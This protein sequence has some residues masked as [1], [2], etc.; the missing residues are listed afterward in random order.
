MVY[1]KYI[2]RGGKLHGPYYY[3]SVRDSKGKIQHVYLG[4]KKPTASSK[5]QTLINSYKPAPLKS[6][7]F[8]PPTKQP[9][10][11]QPTRYNLSKNIFTPKSI[12]FTFIVLLLAI[13]FFFL[14]NYGE[15]TGRVV[16]DI[17]KNVSTESYL[18]IDGISRSIPLT[19]SRNDEGDYYFSISQLDLDL[20][21]GNHTIQLSENQ[22]IVYETTVIVPEQLEPAEELNITLPESTPSLT[23]PELSP[24]IE[25]SPQELNVSLPE[26]AEP[27]PLLSE[28]NR[29][30]ETVIEENTGFIESLAVP[31][32]G[33]P[34]LN[35]T[36]GFNRTSENITLYNISTADTDGDVVKN[37]IT[38]YKNGRSDSVGYY[39]FENG[40]SN[41]TFTKN[42]A[43]VGANGT[44]NATTF[45]RT[46]G[47]DGRGA[48]SFTPTQD[49][50]ILVGNNL[51]NANGNFSVTAW[52]NIS[53]L[54]HNTHSIFGLSRPTDPTNNGYLIFIHRIANSG[55]TLQYDLGV[56]DASFTNAPSADLVPNRWAFVAFTRDSAN[57]RIRIYINDTEVSSTNANPI[58]DNPS[59]MDIV[60]GKWSATQAANVFN[61]TIDEVRIYNYSLSAEQIKAIYAN[62][63]NIIVAQQL[64]ATDVWQGC[65]TPHDGNSDGQIACSNN[66]TIRAN[67]APTHTAPILNATSLT[68]TTLT[69]LTVYNQTT[70]D[71]EGDVVKN[72]ITWNTNVTLVSSRVAPFA[73][74]YYPFEGRDNNASAKDYGRGVLN[75]T[76]NGSFF[77]PTGGFDGRGA[78]EFDAS[79]DQ[80]VTPIDTI[81]QNFTV[82]AWIK[83]RAI[84]PDAGTFGVIVSKLTYFAIGTDSFPFFFIVNHRAANV[85]CAIDAGGDFSQDLELRS[86]GDFGANQWH[87]VAC[88]YNSTH[89]SVYV[90]GKLNATSAST[91]T[92][93][94]GPGLNYTIGRASLHN[95]GGN[96]LTYFNGTIDEVMIFNRSL[97]PRQIEAIYNNRTDL[98]ISSELQAGQLWNSCITPND[99]IDDGV[100][101]CS[102]NV[103]IIAAGTNNLP[104][105]ATPI[106]N[107]TLGTNLTTE[108]L[109]VY[110]RSTNDID[111]D[112]VKNIINWYSNH[113][114][115]HP[116]LTS[117]AALNL[118]FEGG[119]NATFTKDY[120]GFALPINVTN[121]NWNATGGIDAKG[122]Y[123]FNGSS[124]INITAREINFTD[125]ITISVWIKPKSI[126]LGGIIGKWRNTNFA[127]LIWMNANGNISWVINNSN[128]LYTPINLSVNNWN[129]IAV[130][131]NGTAV[132]LYQNGTLVAA[133]AQT[134]KIAVENTYETLIGTYTNVDGGPYNYFNGTID[135]ILIFNRSLS[136]EQIRAIYDNRTDL[137]VSQELEKSQVWYSCITPNDGT[138]D[139]TEICSNNVTIIKANSAPTHSNP[140]LNSTFK[141]NLSSENFTIYFQ[142][143]ADAD[144]DSVQNITDWRRNGTSIAI[145]NM[146]FETNI[147]VNTT[148]ITDY[149]T[150]GIHGVLGNGSPLSLP[151][152]NN[153]GKIGGAYLFNGSNVINLGTSTSA[154][155]STFTIT[156]WIK[157]NYSNSQVLL[158][159]ASGGVSTESNYQLSVA[160]TFAFTIGNGSGTNFVV[161]TT[162]VAT[163]K[164]YF[165]AATYNNA[166]QQL[167][168]YV[169]G[170]FEGNA[171]LRGS[172]FTT[173]TQILKIGAADGTGNDN[174]QVTTGFNGTIDEVMIYNRS[175]SAQQLYQL[176]LDGN[177]SKH[178]ERLV[179]NETRKG[180]NW[181]VAVTPNDNSTDGTILISNGLLILN[182][183]PQHTTPLLNS[184]LGTNRSNE[185]LTVYNQSTFDL[186]GDSVKNIINWK[187]DNY[188]ITLAN[189]PFEGGS[190]STF[191]QDYSGLGNNGTVNGTVWNST[192]GRDGKGAYEFN[193]ASAKIHLGNRGSLEPQ[194]F[195]ITAWIKPLSTAGSRYIFAKTSGTTGYYMT[196][197]S[198]VLLTAVFFTEPGN[199]GF[200]TVDPIP[201]NQWTFVAFTWN[202]TYSTTYINETPQNF[203]N[204]GARTVQHA[205]IEATIGR[206]SN[207][208]TGGYFSGTIDEFTFY[209]KSLSPQQLSALYRNRTD[210]IVRQELKAGESWEACITP[211][212]ET[213]DGNTTCSNNISINGL[214]PIPTFIANTEANGTYKSQE[215]ILINITTPTDI[216]SSYNFTIGNSTTVNT[217]SYTLGNLTS[218]F[219]FSILGLGNDTYRYNVTMVGPGGTNT[220]ETRT[221]ILDTRLPILTFIAST[222]ANG[223]AKAQNFVFLNI[224]ITNE[225]NLANITFSFSN[226]TT[227]NTTVWNIS[228][229]TYSFNFTG[230]LGNDTYRYNVTVRDLANNV[231]TSETRVL[232]L[233]QHLPLISFVTPTLPNN[234]RI[235]QNYLFVNV[236]LNE[237]NFANITFIIGNS[238][239]INTT[240]Y[241]TNTF[242]YNFSTLANT[243]YSYNVTV[244]DLANNVNTSETRTVT[245]DT[246]IPAVSLTNPADDFVT[247]TQDFI[248]FNCSTTD[249]IGLSNISL[250]TNTTGSFI[251]NHTINITG[252]S[253]ATNFTLYGSSL[254]QGIYTWNCR[255]LDTT[256]NSAFSAFNRTF[257]IDRTPPAAT[258]SLASA[259]INVGESTT[260]TCTGTDNIGIELLT[261]TEPTLG[262]I[263]SG[264]TSCTGT[265]T[266]ASAGTY[267]LTCTVRDRVAQVVSTTVTLTVNT[268]S[269]GIPPPPPPPARIITDTDT[270]SAKGAVSSPTKVTLRKGGLTFDLGKNGQIEFSIS[271]DDKPRLDIKLNVED[272]L[273]DYR[274]NPLGY[275]HLLPYVLALLTSVTLLVGANMG[276]TYVKTE[277]KPISLQPAPPQT[278][279]T[280]G[281]PQ[282][283]VYATD[284]E[285]LALHLET[286]SYLLE[287]KQ[288]P[289]ATNVLGALEQA[290][291]RY[292]AS[293]HPEDYEQLARKIQTL[294]IILKKK[295]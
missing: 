79:N 259:T 151:V 10:S 275:F 176:Y 8:T 265:I 186:D 217:T 116:K 130:T 139:G 263:C 107:S 225:N 149:S 29:T 124:S 215:F 271:D 280:T 69:N 208:D 31:T 177:N 268:G 112:N 207:H 240:I 211:N 88:S 33:T 202:G 231:N 230:G 247:S 57:G 261:F 87:H 274:N 19:V 182:T 120:S 278:S 290:T 28:T 157:T 140:I 49:Q 284:L 220:S 171:T 166:T 164:P 25:E 27:A 257:I 185:N 224:S 80:I 143:V 121:A 162:N 279:F 47:Y 253:N 56:G 64:N 169:N 168:I 42:Y 129:H 37:L 7:V 132:A 20:E 241:T 293:L 63:S 133:A 98:I 150:N 1:E 75:A 34:L 159:R 13:S 82:A 92:L 119:S 288:Y 187:R 258:A 209:N 226:S 196:I 201:T 97:S 90:D 41:A 14:S 45:V 66:L 111:G 161:G 85:S 251:L 266:P 110:N 106:L 131:Y 183:V 91:I 153:S 248:T 163:G 235:N 222:E 262:T 95:G 78:Y 229:S 70:S 59:G 188:S 123:E 5:K 40:T 60:I 147:I 272:T 210:L 292:K 96:G 117:Y 30:N 175:L 62:Q 178:M 269:G 223:T 203:I 267:T 137:I 197:S 283:V 174:I 144:G 48:Y 192:G 58:F 101:Q 190:N 44:V 54:G 4:T 277:I 152:W 18:I 99:G 2:K 22:T 83:P 286:I 194:N 89:L 243:T 73:L 156:A 76:V 77:N 214:I 228:N 295:L 206:H 264:G 232:I 227:V 239:M 158:D 172:P 146:P 255:A 86:Q 67:A 50:Y 100:Q 136:P 68:N 16:L 12:G 216:V 127:W 81:L 291:Q 170:T 109:T 114:S 125:N 193:G 23:V 221:I 273:N 237:Q 179:G 236:T 36:R 126:K 238:S 191:T 285:S 234:T 93:A 287:S 155:L 173:G 103:T 128:Y 256:S 9:L 181:T 102:N 122:A 180:E 145:V 38:W 200:T 3:K 74:A 43:A 244:R 138:A 270:D 11:P 204:S 199:S 246:D 184:T 250:F 245:I 53:D 212:D 104:S 281:K 65:I 24:P 242:F 84:G 113:T 21:P 218:T 154:A 205:N 195:T 294:K 72:I 35:S 52:V 46:G 254:A 108:N 105:H 282:R 249:T 219:N 6:P 39:P 189:L 118:P 142:T 17:N 32:Q 289:E 51:I 213:A 233:D 26:L 165:V 260:G 71:V 135:E 276:L 148:N 115:N 198:G 141:T 134:G 55:L 15:V 61:G 94:A 167:S 160:S 252:T